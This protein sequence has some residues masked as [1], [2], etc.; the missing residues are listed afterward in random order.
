METGPSTAPPLP[1]ED[2]GQLV[3]DKIIAMAERSGASPHRLLF[4]KGTTSDRPENGANAPDPRPD[5][6][7][8]A[9]SQITQGR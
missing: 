3:L 1:H 5:L 9:R 4:P 2:P 8:G 6:P 7:R